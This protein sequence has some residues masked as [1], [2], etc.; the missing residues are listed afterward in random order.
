MTARVEI[1]CGDV[2]CLQY[3]LAEFNNN[4][5]AALEWCAEFS[6]MPPGLIALLKQAVARHGS[7]QYLPR[8]RHG[9]P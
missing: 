4:P 7:H 8:R 5:R 6:D 9:S 1:N 2:L 3:L